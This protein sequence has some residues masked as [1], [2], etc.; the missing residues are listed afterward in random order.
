MRAFF[1]QHD[2]L[3]GAVPISALMATRGVDR[4]AAALDTDTY[5]DLG[6]VLSTG[7]RGQPCDLVE[8]H[9]WFNIAACAGHAASAQCRADLALEMMPRDVAE[10]QRRAREWMRGAKRA[11]GRPS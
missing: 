4:Q 2:G 10:A 1:G 7:S 11:V 3:G 5:F 9:K 6:I 8:A